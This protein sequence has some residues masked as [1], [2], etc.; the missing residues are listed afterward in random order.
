M[1]KKEL[2]VYYK[3]IAKPNN[4]YFGGDSYYSP[5]SLIQLQGKWLEDLGFHIGDKINVSYENDRI[6]IEP[7]YPPTI[8]E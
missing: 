5:R 1:R 3:S 8:T 7:I 4:N 2:T 6:I